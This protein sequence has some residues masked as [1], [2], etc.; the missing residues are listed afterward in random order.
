VIFLD[1]SGNEI[2][3]ARLVGFEDAGK[4]LERLE[5]LGAPQASR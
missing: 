4:F 5:R 3:E 2:P 1:A